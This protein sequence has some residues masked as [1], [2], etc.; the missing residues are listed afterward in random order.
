MDIITIARIALELFAATLGQPQD[1][2]CYGTDVLPCA[3]VEVAIVRDGTTTIIGYHN[4]GPMEETDGSYVCTM[5][6]DDCIDKVT[7]ANMD[8]ALIAGCSV[9]STLEMGV[10]KVGDC[11]R[12]PEAMLE[13]AT[14]EYAQVAGYTL[15][16]PLIAP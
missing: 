11:D 3:Y 8:I 16:A 14:L 10:Y 1:A 2:V 5:R 12:L 4:E 15:H 9:G 6:G 7:S 13:R